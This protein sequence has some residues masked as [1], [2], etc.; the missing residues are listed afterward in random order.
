MVG[1]QE[2]RSADLH[3]MLFVWLWG[4]FIRSEYTNFWIFCFKDGHFCLCFFYIS[5]SKHLVI[6]VF[7]VSHNTNSK[8]FKMIFIKQVTQMSQDLL[9]LKYNIY[10]YSSYYCYYHYYQCFFPVFWCGLI[11][12]S[13]L[14]Y[15]SLV[16]LKIKSIIQQID[17]VE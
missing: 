9:T 13:I 3:V 12:C 17:S 10:H 16:T 7:P 2:N 5:S 11:L 6:L 8:L 14:L 1:K 15:I 4:L